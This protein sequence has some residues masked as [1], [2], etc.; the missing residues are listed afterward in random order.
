[1]TLVYIVMGLALVQFLF[2]GYA[3]GAARH[4]Y[5]VKAPATTGNEHFERYFRVQMNTLELLIVLVPALPMFAWFVSARWGALIGVVYLVGRSLY[6]YT[7][8]RDPAKRSLGYTLSLLPVIVL[9]LGGI[10]GAIAAFVKN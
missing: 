10:G 9:L 4:R 8:V 1:M 2:F 3:V 5:G 6:Y 7:Y